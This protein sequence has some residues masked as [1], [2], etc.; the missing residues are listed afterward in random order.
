MSKSSGIKVIGKMRITPAK[1]KEWLA[2]TEEWEDT[3]AEHKNRAPGQHHVEELMVEML[4]D[5]WRCTNQGIL[6]GYMDIIIDGRQRLMAVAKSGVTCEMIVHQ[7]ESLL[8]AR[9]LPIDVRGRP[10][11]EWWI[12]RKD[13]TL[14]EVAKTI[15]TLAAQSPS[16]SA[17][18]KVAVSG[19]DVSTAVDEISK[20]EPPLTTTRRRH[21]CQ[22]PVRSIAY[23]TMVLSPDRAGEIAEQYRAIALGDPSVLWPI[24]SSFTTQV[25]TAAADQREMGRDELHARTWRVFTAS[26]ARRRATKM[27]IKDMA[28]AQSEIRSACRSLIARWGIDL[29]HPYEK[30]K[31]G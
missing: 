6:L 5:A 25:L 26:P 4:S 16:C 20:I 15:V 7:D 17:Y 23:L 11:S 13:R 14:W 21:L 31:A 1:A 3:H 8:G 30:R 18:S 29:S 2:I 22:A 10:R 9:D 24:T 28:L 19:K 27:Q 12:R